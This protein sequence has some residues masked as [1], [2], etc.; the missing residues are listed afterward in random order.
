LRFSHSLSQ[1]TMTFIRTVFFTHC[2]PARIIIHKPTFSTNLSHNC[3]PTYLLH[4]VCALAAPLSRQPRLRTSPSRVAG[5]L[6]AQEAISLM[7][8]GAGRLKCER[9]L[10]TA[11]ALCI[12]QFHEIMTKDK[13][14][15]WSA[16][17]HRESLPRF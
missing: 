8:D 16:S 13:D 15:H 5:K 7:F 11:Q 1:E 3:L 9:N 14:M 2:H 6:F 12:L 10:E 17:Y 4:A